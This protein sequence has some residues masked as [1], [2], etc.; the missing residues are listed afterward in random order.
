MEVKADLTAML[1]VGVV[2][3]A[4]FHGA[5]IEQVPALADR[6]AVEQPRADADPAVV[7]AGRVPMGE[8]G[9]G[10][11]M[12]QSDHPVAP[13]VR[14]RFAGHSDAAVVGGVGHQRPELP[15]NAAIAAA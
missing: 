10:R 9:A 2:E 15:A 4:H 11:A 1:A 5:A 8:A 12:M 3:V 13:N 7:L 14:R 6:E